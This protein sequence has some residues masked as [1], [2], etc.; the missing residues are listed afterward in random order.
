MDES[1]LKNLL[2]ALVKA[3][4][5]K[6]LLWRLE[7]SANLSVQGVKVSIDSLN[8]ATNHDGL[9][10][11]QE[12]LVEHVPQLRYDEERKAHV[13]SCTIQNHQLEILA[14]HDTDLQMLG[15]IRL[16]AWQGLIL[17]ILP[18]ELA[19]QFYEAVSKPEKAQLIQQYINEHLYL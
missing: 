18:L 15:R 5:N 12:C 11:F 14:Y 8:I 17:P 7:G 1:E 3:T 16:T 13:L 19:K 6:P 9:E 4:R 10:L 2:A